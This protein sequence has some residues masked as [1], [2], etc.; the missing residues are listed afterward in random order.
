MT[1]LAE[2]RP[3]P[4]LS[5]RAYGWYYDALAGDGGRPGELH[6]YTRQ[7]RLGG[8]PVLEPACGAGR[9]LAAVRAAGLEV[10]G[11]DAEPAMLALAA[12]R[13]P[14]APLICQTLTALDLSQTFGTV[15]L[16]LDAVRL[17]ADAGE[18]TALLTAVRRHL[19]PGGRLALDLELPTAPLLDSGWLA[20]VPHP[21]GGHTSARARRRL[22]GGFLLE[23]TCYRTTRTDG[24]TLE[25]WSVEHY[26]LLTAAELADALAAAGFGEVA[27]WSDFEGRPPQP[28]TTLLVLAATAEERP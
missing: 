20:P 14:G 23:E 8:G 25:E 7:A 27:C 5:W 17:T 18:L 9:V 28:G 13:L 1:P 11:T 19:R 16:T 10:W 24:S 21:A 15:L 6:F 2:P 3:R 22:D 4:G 26:R 12:R